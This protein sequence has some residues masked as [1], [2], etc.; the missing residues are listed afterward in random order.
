MAESEPTPPQDDP[1][2]TKPAS[3]ATSSGAAEP[4]PILE[5][6]EDLCPKC[7]AV[8]GPGEVVCM[9]CGYDLRT[10]QAHEPRVGVEHVKADAVDAAATPGGAGSRAKRWWGSAVERVSTAPASG[11]KLEEFS[12]AGR[13]GVKTLM[14][15]AAGLV[16]AAMVISGIE[17]HAQT[18]R[19]L[20]TVGR[21]M[22]TLYSTLLATGLGLAA[23]AVVARVSDMRLGRPDLATARMLVAFAAFEVISSITFSG[24]VLLVK[25]LMWGAGIAAYWVLVM[26]L[27]KKPRHVAGY[28]LATHFV[29]YL[30]LLGGM[31]LAG[32]VSQAEA[33]AATAKAAAAHSP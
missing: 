20:A 10:N 7:Q 21:V 13:G 32:W 17:T 12:Q 16:I 22:L 23:V 15:F 1:P 27:F 31:Q 28:V 5:I 9:R 29:L 33:S 18:G 24:P 25:L 4:K 30:L 11:K 19:A 6:E 26:V 14:I 2:T 3:D 8:L